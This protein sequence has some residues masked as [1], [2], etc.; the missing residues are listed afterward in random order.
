M[1]Q[2]RRWTLGYWQ[3]VRRHGLLH[4]GRF[5]TALTLQIAELISSIISLL[6]LP[7]ML[8]AVYSET[9]ASRYGNRR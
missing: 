1:G 3:T 5:W 2:I 9:L 4:I 6:M 7:S 8:L